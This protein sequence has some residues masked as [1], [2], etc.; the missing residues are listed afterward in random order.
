[1][2][3][4]DDIKEGYEQLLEVIC[5]RHRSEKHYGLVRK[6]VGQIVAKLGEAAVPGM[7]FEPPR[8][9]TNNVVSETG[10][11]QTGLYSHRSRLEA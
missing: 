10:P 2:L 9:K 3:G 1:M 8:G 7:V 6:A 5:S 11:T 4:S